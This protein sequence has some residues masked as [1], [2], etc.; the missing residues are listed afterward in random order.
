MQEG[1]EG[2]GTPKTFSLLRYGSEKRGNG[3]KEDRTTKVDS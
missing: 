2:A 3:W 1:S